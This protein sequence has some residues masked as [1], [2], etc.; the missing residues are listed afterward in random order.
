MTPRRPGPGLLA[1][2]GWLCGVLSALVGQ[3]LLLR[4]TPPPEAAADARP[5]GRAAWEA[6]L[7]A[8]DAALSAAPT[9]SVPPAW[10]PGW[11]LARLEATFDAPTPDC[12]AGPPPTLADCADEAPCVLVG[13]LPAGAAPS[14]WPDLPEAHREER[15]VDGEGGP[16]A[17]RVVALEAPGAAADPARTEQRRAVLLERAA[18]TW[19]PAAARAQAWAPAAGKEGGVAGETLVSPAP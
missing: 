12:P 6:R 18:F 17:V 10:P 16:F 2:L 14:C 15:P 3:R 7:D 11:S 13:L 8:L 9:V 19:G 5:A 1:G 4:A